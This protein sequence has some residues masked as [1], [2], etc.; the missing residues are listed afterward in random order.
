MG[1]SG[2]RDIALQDQLIELLPKLRRFAR[3]LAGG[4][5][6]LGDDIAQSAIARALASIDSFAPGT[7]LDSWMYKIAQ[8][9]WI[10][11]LRGRRS[12]TQHVSLEVVENSAGEDGRKIIE[13]RSLLAATRCAIEQ[14]PPEQRMVVM[15]VL[16]DGLSYKEAAEV[17]SLPIGTIMSRTHRARAALAAKVFA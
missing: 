9:I 4:D 6:D 1:K 12:Q 16:V 15:L 17:L 11:Q 7:R 2:G 10:D 14:L 5:R 13:D 8:N 3:S